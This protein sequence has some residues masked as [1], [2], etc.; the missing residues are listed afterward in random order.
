MTTPKE[1]SAR[2]RSATEFP[3]TI[4]SLPQPEANKLYE[5]MRDCLIFTNRSR[6]Q[7]QRRN[8]ESKQSA[9]RFKTD[10]E[11][12]QSMLGQLKQEKEQLAESNR[13]I[14]SDLEHELSSMVG[15]MDR[16]SKAFDSV[17]DVENPDQVYWSALASPSR[18]MNFLKAIKAIVMWWREDKGVEGKVNQLSQASP[19]HLPGSVDTDERREKPQM[20]TDPASVGRALLD[21]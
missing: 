13:Q 12:L 21:K 17:S 2:F 15:Q 14:V 10:L 9:I 3:K 7:L 16:L 20:H 11:R 5:E 1:S 4:E 18:F 8:E 19:S 6:A